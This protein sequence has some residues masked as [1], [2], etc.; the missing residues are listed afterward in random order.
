ML[1]ADGGQDP[2]EIVDPGQGITKLFQTSSLQYRLEHM[3]KFEAT[4][5]FMSR[6]GE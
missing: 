3:K 1:I 2:R 5:P 6:S 4:D